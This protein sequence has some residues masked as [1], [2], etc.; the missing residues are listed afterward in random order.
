MD[1]WRSGCRWSGVPPC[2]AR[3]CSPGCCAGLVGDLI[4]IAFLVSRRWAPYDKW[5][6]TVF[7]LAALPPVG[8]VEQWV[9]SVDVLTDVRLRAAAAGVCRPFPG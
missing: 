9:D 6:E 5:L 7:P 8:S 3:S 4:R 1:G 2:G